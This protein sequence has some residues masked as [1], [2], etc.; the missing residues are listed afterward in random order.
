M[1]LNEKFVTLRPAFI[2]IGEKRPFMFNLLR[3]QSQDI[4]LF[5]NQLVSSCWQSLVWFQIGLQ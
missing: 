5:L 2:L 4:P 1:T 3:L